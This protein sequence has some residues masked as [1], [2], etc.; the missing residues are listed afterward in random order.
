MTLG[1]QAA[2]SDFPLAFKWKMANLQ[3][4]ELNKFIPSCIALSQFYGI[5]VS[6]DELI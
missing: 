4:P 6:F 2:K 3:S 1:R 5:F